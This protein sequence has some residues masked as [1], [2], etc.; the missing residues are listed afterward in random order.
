MDAKA[1]VD[2]TARIPAAAACRS[3]SRHRVRAMSYSGLGRS[4]ARTAKGEEPDSGAQVWNPGV[5]LEQSTAGS[6][7]NTG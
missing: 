5:A 4:L 6:H 2:A 1:F 7:A 3:Q